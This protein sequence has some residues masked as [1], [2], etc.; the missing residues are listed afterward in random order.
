MGQPDS[1]TVI[2]SIE[3]GL[4]QIDKRHYGTKKVIPQRMNTFANRL[5]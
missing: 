3:S 1:F 4:R 2:Q 5:I